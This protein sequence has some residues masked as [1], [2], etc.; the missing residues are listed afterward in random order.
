[1]SIKLR[2]AL[3]LGLLLLAFLGSLLTLRHFEGLKA[4]QALLDA[5]QGRSDLMERWLD[6]TG[7]SLRQFA[8]DY[9]QWDDLVR[10]VERPDANWAAVNIDAGLANFNACAAW[11]LRRDGT[12]IHAANP[13]KEPELAQPPVPA[14]AWPALAAGNPF[15]HFFA[16]CARGLLEIRSAPIQPSDDA[17]RSTPPRGWF[18]VARLWDDAQRRTLEQ[19]TESRVSLTEPQAVRPRGEADRG[20]IHL[21]RPLMDWQGHTVRV[22]QFDFAAPEIAQWHDANAYQ[23]GVFAAFGLLVICALALGLQRWVLQ[24]LARIS[25]SLARGD[26]APIQPLLKERERTELGRVAMLIESAFAQKT[27]LLREIEER[28]RAEAALRESDAVLRSTLEERARLGRDLHDSVIQSLYAAGMGLVGIREQLRRDPAEAEAR[29]DQAR[30]A[31]NETIR[32]VRYFIIGL[33]PEALKEQSFTHAVERLIEFMRA[34]QPVEA[35]IA[36]DEPLAVQLTL[37]QRA[38]ALQIAREAVSNA[39]RHGRASHV[40]LSLGRREGHVEFTIEDDGCGFDPATRLGPG[41]GL[42]NLAARAGELGAELR[43]ISEPGKGT[44]V[45]VV[46]P[47][48]VPP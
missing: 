3:L 22:L 9:S 6:L 24:P 7:A 5:R 15:L 18:M 13:L 40:R 37:M 16:P 25:D 48:P 33:E 36:V 14:S 11:V 30:A 4:E 34:M 44:R 45:T 38:H 12:T 20:A 10:Y 29:I 47:L 43:V 32:D 21:A 41:R 19:L 17:A 28:E 35:I 42:H 31:L 39:L 26:T 27:R 1:M 23:V 2:L 8:N 46:F